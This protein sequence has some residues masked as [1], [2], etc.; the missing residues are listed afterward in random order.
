[1]SINFRFVITS[2]FIYLKF[3]KLDIIEKSRFL[4]LQA[5]IKY[6]IIDIIL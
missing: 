5:I 4:S 1:M 2:K 6:K 3:E